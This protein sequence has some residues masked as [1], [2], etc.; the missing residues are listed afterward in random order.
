MTLRDRVIPFQ[1]SKGMQCL[2]LQKPRVPSERRK[3]ITLPASQRNVPKERNPQPH[4]CEN[5][6][7]RTPSDSKA[8]VQRQVCRVTCGCRS[9]KYAFR[10]VQPDF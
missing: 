7:A 5:I 4:R 10:H 8:S 2:H 6:K 1:R 3:P 9:K